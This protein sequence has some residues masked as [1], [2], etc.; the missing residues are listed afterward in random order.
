M[1]RIDSRMVAMFTSW[2]P[3]YSSELLALIGAF[4]L[5]AFHRLYIT[6]KQYWSKKGIPSE[7][8]LP[9]VG[10]ISDAALSKKPIGEVY[11]DIYVKNEEYRY[12]GFHKF[13]QPAILLRDPELI[14][15]I[16]VDDCITHF[17]A[18]EVHGDED[19]DPMFGR[20]L[21]ALSGERWRRLRE[22]VCP[23]FA[24]A[25]IREIFDL[26]PEVCGNL[27]GHISQKLKANQGSWDEELRELSTN[28]TTSTMSTCALGIPCDAINH[29]GVELR[30][31]GKMLLEPTPKKVLSQLIFLQIPWL[32]KLLRIPFVPREVTEYF[33]KTVFEEV[34][35][36]E[37][38]GVERNDYMQMFIR[39][40]KEG[41]LRPNDGNSLKQLTDKLKP[42]DLDD[43]TA[44]ALAFFADGFV[45]T[46][47]LISFTLFE[48]AH[49][50]GLQESLRGEVWRAIDKHGGSLTYDALEEMELMDMVLHETLRLYPPAPFM[51][52]SC[53]KDYQLGSPFP[54]SNDSPGFTLEK[55]IPVVVPVYG[56]QR[57]P[58]YYPN[59]NEFDPRR[60]SGRA[61]R[62]KKTFTYYPYGEGPRVCIGHRFG[63]LQAKSAIATVLRKFEMHPHER[64]PRRIE[65]DPHYF[66]TV[67][68]GGLWVRFEHRD[69]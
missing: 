40:W 65:L 5:Y 43:I 15:R 54:E 13:T 30:R 20:H 53:S 10:S 12:V 52:R 25:K 19:L 26:L 24:F 60:F 46:G 36:R 17:P 50:K 45:T 4:G 42:K 41:N 56:I 3:Q 11:A 31:M 33:R 57:D 55:G 48:L 68:K 32:A 9:L 34:Y 28:F 27:E 18:N 37:R 61:Q 63:F 62:E 44:L 29:P 38:E 8:Y 14:R 23:G 58:K 64:T 59:P 49:D 47:T 16:I 6:P 1:F 51:T 69:Y 67:A 39:L 66:V 21:F 35:R 7:K 22:S 2:I